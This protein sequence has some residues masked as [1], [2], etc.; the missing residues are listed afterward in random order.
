MILC[1][2]RLIRLGRP[3]CPAAFFSEAC[4]RF[5]Q[6]PGI[7]GRRANGVFLDATKNFP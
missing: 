4:G 2:V 1:H 6:E 5:R 7:K 3:R